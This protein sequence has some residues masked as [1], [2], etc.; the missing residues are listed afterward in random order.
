LQTKGGF[1][2]FLFCRRLKNS[3]KSVRVAQLTVP[4]GTVRRSVGYRHGTKLENI[5]HP[6]SRFSFA[7]ANSMFDVG[8]SVFDVPIEKSAVPEAGAPRY[9]LPGVTAGIAVSPGG[10][11]PVPFQGVTTR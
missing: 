1:L 9:L 10:R 4:F 7:P 8:R 5:E 3:V 2:L 6:T 11:L